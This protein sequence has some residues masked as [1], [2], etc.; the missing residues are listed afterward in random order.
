MKPSISLIVAALN[1][2]GNIEAAVRDILRAAEGCFSSYELLIVND[3][4]TDQTG[5]IAD[6]LRAADPNI[7]VIHH[8]VNQGLGASLREGFAVAS[9]EFVFWYPG[10]NPMHY[11]SM[12]EMFRMTGKADLIISYVA[13][14]SFRSKKRR[15]I[16]SLYVILMNLLFGLKLKYFNAIS[17]YRTDLI[18]Q[19]QTSGTGFAFFAEILI[20]MLRSGASY[21]EVPTHHRLRTQGTSKAFSLKNFIDI[22]STLSILLWDV[23]VRKETRTPTVS[24][25]ERI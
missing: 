24:S 4:S 9:K 18:N 11:D 19:T 10:D 1:E 20:R 21:I 23:Y 7:K 5:K 12:V 22:L 25:M 14:P 15:F 17:I 2:E 6:R 16:S 13:N 3:G 8:A